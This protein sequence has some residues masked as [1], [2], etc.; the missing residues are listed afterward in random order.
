MV[1]E[2]VTNAV[3]EM[4][5]ARPGCLSLL[6]PVC[7]QGAC[8]LYAYI[9]GHVPGERKHSQRPGGSKCDLVRDLRTA[10]RAGQ[11]ARAVLM[12]GQGQASIAD[13]NL[14]G[15]HAWNL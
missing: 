6:R 2:D 8:E 1:L 12:P 7:L 4:R 11:H 15:S 5:P 10:A 3:L 9:P 14:G 13:L